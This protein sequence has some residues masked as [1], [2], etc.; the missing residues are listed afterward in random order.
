MASRPYKASEPTKTRWSAIA[1]A[2]LL[3]AATA[4]TIHLAFGSVERIRNDHNQI[5]T[6]I[7]ER[8]DAK[9]VQELQKLLE[10]K[11]SVDQ[12]EMDAY[13]SSPNTHFRTLY[14]YIS[15]RVLRY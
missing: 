5:K 11:V 9:A 10:S 6:D 2:A 1:L 15:I 7:V 12:A 13:T 8:H 14:D 4:S 3:G